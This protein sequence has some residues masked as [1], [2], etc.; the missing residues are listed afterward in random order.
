MNKLTRSM[1]RAILITLLASATGTAL[2]QEPVDEPGKKR[3]QHQRGYQVSPGVDR[4]MRAIRRL[5][6]S[7]TQKSDI[8]AVM[9][10][11]K[12]EN[13]QIT[14]EMRAG[15][16]QLNELI[17]ADIYDEAAV[18][19]LAEQEGALAAER[20]II[21]SRAM[22]QVYGLLTDE[23]RLELEAMAERRKE[24]RAGKRAAKN[25]N[26]TDNG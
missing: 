24:K 12:A 18:A 25:K 22:S 21:S 16:N 11:L 19:T 14:K 26:P 7:E 10:G 2:A 1:T 13:R 15:Y 3:M 17:K 20:L 5:D 8:K 9:Q 6:L 4:M 23:Q